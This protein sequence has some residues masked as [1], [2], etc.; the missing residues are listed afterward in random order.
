MTHPPP[1]A[2]AAIV[3]TPAAPAASPSV[4]HPRGDRQDLAARL[5]SI[6]RQIVQLRKQIDGY[7]QKTRLHDVLGGLGYILGLTGLAYYFL[8]KK[9]KTKT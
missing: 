3:G 9:Q 5:E 2:A 8:G 1:S 4:G 7:E 6:D